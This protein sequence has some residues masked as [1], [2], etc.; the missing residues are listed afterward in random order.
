MKQ[1][2]KA[3]KGRVEKGCLIGKQHTERL[4]WK[5]EK[6]AGRFST[7]CQICVTFRKWFNLQQKKTSVMYKDYTELHPVCEGAL[8][9]WTR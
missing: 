6:V 8:C 9:S 4:F 7:G 5:R 2:G 1:F 3:T